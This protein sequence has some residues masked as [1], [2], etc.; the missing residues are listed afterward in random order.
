LLSVEDE[1]I[2]A[3]R[4]G[5]TGES[6]K[7]KDVH[8]LITEWYEM[9][10]V[11]GNSIRAFFR[12]DRRLISSAVKHN[13]RSRRMRSIRQLSARPSNS[14]RK[15]MLKRQNFHQTGSSSSR[16]PLTDLLKFGII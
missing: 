12:L 3:D 7:G 5:C 6:G 1:T 9:H 15:V 4:A 16:A 11:S 10:G 8:S 2:L 14:V 13:P